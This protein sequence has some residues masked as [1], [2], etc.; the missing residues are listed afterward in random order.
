MDCQALRDPSRLRAPVAVK[1]P[2]SSD[3]M[4]QC[5]FCN[6]KAKKQQTKEVVLNLVYSNCE[7]LP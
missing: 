4:A 3:P 7:D 6:I 1:V 2:S 5:C